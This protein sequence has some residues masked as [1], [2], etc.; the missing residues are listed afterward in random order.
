MSLQNRLHQFNSGRGLQPK[1][2][3]ILPKIILRSAD[4]TCYRIAVL[5]IGF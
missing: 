4:P 1:L 5:V 2:L 3:K